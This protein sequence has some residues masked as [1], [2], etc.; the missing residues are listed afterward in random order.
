MLP[1]A[2][3]LLRQN[4]RIEEQVAPFQTVLV[5]HSSPAVREEHFMDAS[6]PVQTR[7][8]GVTA[9]WVG[10][11]VPQGFNTSQITDEVV[12]QLDSRLL[13]SRERFGK[14]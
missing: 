6:V 10:T 14:I 11:P 5:R 4:Y 7:S 13:A 12:R 2:K 8:A 1:L 9:A 3:R